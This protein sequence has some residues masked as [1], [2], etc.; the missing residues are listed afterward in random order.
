MKTYFGVR[1]CVI[2]LA[3]TAV[4][5]ASGAD[6][7]LGGLQLLSGYQHV[8][9]Q[10][11]DSAVGEIKKE[12]GLRIMYEI[13]RVSKPGSP[14]MGGDFRDR[15]KL[16]PKEMLQWY[17]EQTV[18]DQPV[19]LALSKDKVLLASFPKVGMN[20]TTKVESSEDLVDALLMILTYP[21]RLPPFGR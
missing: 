19:H 3:L 13:G 16:M 15:A 14:Q 12:G 17:R 21:K 18:N 1:S 11:I 4:G 5:S 20:F 7:P 6:A 2:L 8:P 9:L 10:G